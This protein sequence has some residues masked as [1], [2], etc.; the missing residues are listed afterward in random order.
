MNEENIKSAINTL[1]NFMQEMNRWEIG[2]FAQYFD[3]IE[4]NADESASTV[5]EKNILRDLIIIFDKYLIS[6]VKNRNRI[7]ALSPADPPDYDCNYEIIINAIE[8]K[9][10][11]VIETKQ[12]RGLKS[13]FRYTVSVKKGTFI[14]T[15][16]ELYE[17]NGKW[18]AIGF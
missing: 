9:K 4:N 1:I 10:S 6:G 7:A 5:A 2:A 14:L 8:E 16:K 15:K 12:D 13:K 17:A 18:S 11:I 3:S